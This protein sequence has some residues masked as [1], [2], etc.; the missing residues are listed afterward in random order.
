[1]PAMR[2][3]M[4]R[5]TTFAFGF[6]LVA[7]LLLSSAAAAQDVDVDTYVV[8]EITQEDDTQFK[9]LIRGDYETRQVR[10][11]PKQATQPA[12]APRKIT[13]YPPIVTLRSGW[14]YATGTR[15]IVGTDRISAA[16]QSTDLV[17]WISG[18]RHRIYYWHGLGSAKVK[19]FDE[20]GNEKF[21]LSLGEYAEVDTSVADPEFVRGTFTTNNPDFP[22]I[23][24][25]KRDTYMQNTAPTDARGVKAT[26]EPRPAAATT[27]PRTT[28]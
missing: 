22:N 10:A 14:L 27:Q 24:A 15:P 28:R 19:I 20:D 25:T 12:A 21:D 5:L 18:S 13:L 11:M 6:G 17:V 16:A 23:I 9:C 26:N 1:M 2:R 4:R 7:T 8:L 3:P